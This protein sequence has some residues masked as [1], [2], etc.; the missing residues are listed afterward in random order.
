MFLKRDWRA[1]CCL[2]RKKILIKDGNLNLDR[3]LSLSQMTSESNTSVPAEEFLDQ[4]RIQAI[5]ANFRFADIAN[6][7]K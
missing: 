2:K 5:D 7:K 3:D 1:S 6:A 4:K